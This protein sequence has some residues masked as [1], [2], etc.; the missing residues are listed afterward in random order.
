MYDIASTVSRVANST[1]SHT[2]RIMPVQPW[3]DNL[4]SS[5]HKFPDDFEL[6]L[7]T[8]LT[9][10]STAGADYLLRTAG[11]GLVGSLALPSSIAPRQL[12]R[13]M[14]NIGF[15]RNK[16]SSGDP[17]RFFKRPDSSRVE[18]QSSSAGALRFRPKD[19]VSELL[20]FDSP[21]RTV[22]PALRDS[23]PRQRRNMRA[24]AQYWRHHS[25]PRPTICVIHGFM[26]DPYW[27]NRLFFALPW[28]Y[29]QGYDILLYTLPHHGKRRSRLSPFSGHGLFASGLCHLNESMAHAV[30]DFRIFMD[31]L[32]SRGVNKIGVTGISLGGYTSA[33]LA[34]VE[35]RLHF[36]IPN[37]PVA[38]LPDLVLEW[39]PMNMAIKSLLKL[40]G[41]SVREARHMLA[42]HSPL[43]YSPRIPRERLMVIA[44]AGD[45][46]A[47]P[48]H[49]RLLWDHWDRCRIHWFPGN[50]LLHLDKGKYLKE[51]ARFLREI[52]F[53]RN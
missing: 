48:K 25:G 46:L 4:E 10:D 16:A 38:S 32:E 15:Y 53:D 12:R 44:G 6:D 20:S 7:R 1:Y 41:T 35:E 31:Y 11:A 34:A 26:A 29:R 13:D 36:S 2:R 24:V 5:F 50:H 22:N 40:S 45:R 43:T 18:V 49:A 39:F 8:E 27:L 17:D 52:G 9:V 33:L 3:W 28:F 19:G 42:V 21:F 47:P 23:Y 51:M 14:A 30:H 37:V